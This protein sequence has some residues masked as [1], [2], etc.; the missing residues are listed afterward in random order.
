MIGVL[1]DLLELETGCW[2][3]QRIIELVNANKNATFLSFI[4]MTP[5]S[6][7]LQNKTNIPNNK[8]YKL[9]YLVVLK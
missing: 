3:A 9:Y 6:N 8:S 1:D 2:Q 4:R 7:L 5:F